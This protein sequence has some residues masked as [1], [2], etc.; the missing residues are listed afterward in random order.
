MVIDE[1]NVVD[2][3][4]VFLEQQ[5]QRRASDIE[6]AELIELADFTH[7]LFFK[8]HAMYPHLRPMY[9]TV[10]RTIPR[11]IT[12]RAIRWVN[13]ARMYPVSQ[14]SREE[15][16]AMSKE[17]RAEALTELAKYRREAHVIHNRYNEMIDL[18]HEGKLPYHINYAGVKVENLDQYLERAERLR[19]GVDEWEQ[20]L[21]REAVVF[22]EEMNKQDEKFDDV[23]ALWEDG[24]PPFF[25]PK[26]GKAKKAPMRKL[27]RDGNKIGDIKVNAREFLFVPAEEM[28]EGEDFWLPKKIAFEGIKQGG[29]NMRIYEGIADY[30]MSGVQRFLDQDGQFMTELPGGRKVIINYEMGAGRDPVGRREG[31]YTQPDPL[32]RRGQAR[33]GAGDPDAPPSGQKA[34]ELG[35]E[36]FPHERAMLP[37]IPE[38]VQRQQRLP[39]LTA[40]A[41]V[42]ESEELLD[43]NAGFPEEGVQVGKGEGKRDPVKLNALLNM[44]KENLQIDPAKQALYQDGE[45][46]LKN[47]DPSE[48]KFIKTLGGGGNANARNGEVMQVEI[49]GKR[50]V[51]KVTPGEERAENAMYV[52]DRVLGIGVMP[53]IQI[54]QLGLQP[55]RDAGVKGSKLQ[56][57]N[58]YGKEGA[59][60]LQE[61]HSDTEKKV[62]F[63][64]EKNRNGAYGMVL[65]DMML[66]NSDRHNYNWGGNA[67][68]NLVI[69]DN[70]QAGRFAEVHAP[71]VRAKGIVKWEIHRDHD[72]KGEWWNNV[73]RPTFTLRDSDN[74]RMLA[75]QIKAEAGAW[76]DDHFDMQKVGQAAE[77]GHMDVLGKFMNG[78]DVTT[79][80]VKERFVDS[81]LLATGH[82]PASWMMNYT[83][84][85][86]IN[87]DA[88]PPAEIGGEA[89]TP[90][91]SAPDLQAKMEFDYDG[92]VSGL[93]NEGA[94]PS[95]ID[96]AMSPSNMNLINEAI[97]AGDN[98]VE[99]RENI[100]VAINDMALKGGDDQMDA[101]ALWTHVLEHKPELV[102][103]SSTPAANE[104][105]EPSAVQAPAPAPASVGSQREYPEGEDPGAP[106][107][108]QIP[109]GGNLPPAE[110]AAP[111]PPQVT[112]ASPAAASAPA[113]EAPEGEPSDADLEEEFEYDVSIPAESGP[114]PSEAQ[115]LGLNQEEWA[116]VQD[117]RRRLRDFSDPNRI[118]AA[119]EEAYEDLQD[120]FGGLGNLN[121][122]D[123]IQN[124]AAIKQLDRRK[125]I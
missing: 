6:K 20:E 26:R 4:D 94:P 2:L 61:M 89:P 62:D 58:R 38:R 25:D 46:D 114:L 66:G 81:I 19:A 32:G 47:L 33:H 96:A 12:F 102:Q 15:I 120:E 91:P 27:D 72:G 111:S 24:I 10:H 39:G 16:A 14:L 84:S 125:Y 110:G 108:G 3:V 69:F 42:V 123:L 17:E 7:G 119:A 53:H 109:W 40:P 70:G 87:R 65:L 83:K 64:R 54:A 115:D 23:D 101:A 51:Y 52:M 100:L 59:G 75:T 50:Y 57:L 37:D 116:A 9:R 74:N 82:N 21:D 92:V 34:P 55:F 60:F 122:S 97:L 48:V 13:P 124:S 73:N 29:R 63:T 8:Q 18:I 76:F 95:M 78:E 44:A 98:D 71:N 118:D 103:I 11:Q 121:V 80:A 28:R 36:A 88:P 43:P 112:P 35:G 56:M 45:P 107:S 99:K 90:E 104:I 1:K 79:E 68:G 31:R 5:S 77:M 30:N 49:R 41:A 93:A 22:R 86:R 113:A 67:D 117:V 106:P 85:D 105:S